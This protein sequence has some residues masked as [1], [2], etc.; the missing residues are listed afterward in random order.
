MGGPKSLG[1]AKEPRSQ[2]F[3]RILRKHAELLLLA[4]RAILLP[5]P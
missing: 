2:A 4:V 1:V 5:K 3:D